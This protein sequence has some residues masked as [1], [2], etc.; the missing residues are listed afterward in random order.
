MLQ[1]EY[2]LKNLYDNILTSRVI[3]YSYIA[4]TY[5]RKNTR[6]FLSIND[7]I[8]F[9]NN[10]M[11]FIRLSSKKK[12][13]LNKIY[14]YWNGFMQVSDRHWLLMSMFFW[15]QFYYYIAE[16]RDK[17]IKELSEI[18]NGYCLMFKGRWCRN[19]SRCLQVMVCRKRLKEINS[20]N[21]WKVYSRT[22]MTI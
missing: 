10:L 6:I 3:K 21:R 1:I 11:Q 2:P 16:L 14:L 19:V 18:T 22:R 8:N 9:I 13:N 15:H 12:K 7:K 17:T 4:Y 5:S 20:L